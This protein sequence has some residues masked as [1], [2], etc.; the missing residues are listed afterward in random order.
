MIADHSQLT[1]YTCGLLFQI[2]SLWLQKEV[3]YAHDQQ[4]SASEFDELKVTRTFDRTHTQEEL[5]GMKKRH[6]D[7]P[8]QRTPS[9]STIHTVQVTC[10]PRAIRSLTLFMRA[11]EFDKLSD[12][13]QFTG[14]PSHITVLVATEGATPVTQVSI[15]MSQATMK[16]IRTFEPTL[17]RSDD[18]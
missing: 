14:R 4:R 9:L 1:G 17:E 3:L 10:I 2:K 7:M 15:D 13:T 5:R 8:T 6:A 18:G 11:K 12:D 16:M